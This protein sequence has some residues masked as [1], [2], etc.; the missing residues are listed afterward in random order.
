MTEKKRQLSQDDL[1][2]IAGGDLTL[3]TIKTS[4]SFGSSLASHYYR[5]G[6]STHLRYGRGGKHGGGSS[7]TYT[8][9]FAI[10]VYQSGFAYIEAG[11]TPGYVSKYDEKKK[12][13]LATPERPLIELYHYIMARWPHEILGV[14]TGPNF[15]K[16]REERRR[17]RLEERQRDGSAE[18]EG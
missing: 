1:E 18:Q 16:L 7:N 15:R 5:K 9:S 14:E 17:K 6:L 3:R 13:L 10:K 11:G 4:A 12:A 8:R 2:K